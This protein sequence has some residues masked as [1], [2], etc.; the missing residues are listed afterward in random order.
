MQIVFIRAAFL[1]SFI[2]NNLCKTIT[3]V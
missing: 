1:H 3:F 2:N